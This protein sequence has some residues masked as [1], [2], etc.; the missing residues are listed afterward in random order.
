MLEVVDALRSLLEPDP[1]LVDDTAEMPFEWQ[2]GMLYVF[3]DE[4]N[5][6]RL[7][8]GGM[9][10]ED[11]VIMAVYVRPADEAPLAKRSREVTEALDARRVRYLTTIADNPSMGAA[12]GDPDEPPLWSHI[13]GA[14][15]PRYLRELEVRGIAVR[16]VGYRL[17]S[18]AP[19]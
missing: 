9:I 18:V 8:T 15:L 12:S 3:E 2:P 10:R 13:M 17:M 6:S 4:S 11:F 14:S 16:V 7:D 5:W 19:G 1:D